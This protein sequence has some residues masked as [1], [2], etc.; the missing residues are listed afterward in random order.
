[1]FTDGVEGLFFDP[2]DMGAALRCLRRLAD[3]PDLRTRMGEAGKARYNQTFHLDNMV[4]KVRELKIDAELE[5]CASVLCREAVVER[6]GGKR[7]EKR[8][9][10]KKQEL[11]S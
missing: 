1:M 11:S 2:N 8:S 5:T 7:D 4:E 9:D 10:E 3:D 6:M